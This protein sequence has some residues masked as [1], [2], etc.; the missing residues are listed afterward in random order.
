MDVD[1]HQNRGKDQSGRIS[2]VF[3]GKSWSRAVYRFK[4]RPFFADVGCSN[5]SDRTGDLSGYV[6]YDVTI[7]IRH[8]DHIE[9]LGFISEFGR[10]DIDN[11][12]FM[13]DSGILFSDLV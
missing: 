3:T 10:T 11:P 1:E 13:F 7:E 12:V 9:I 6:R 5:E 4:H 2:C 8:Y